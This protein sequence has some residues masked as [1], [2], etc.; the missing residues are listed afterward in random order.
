M[1]WVC[2]MVGF[3]DGKYEGGERS[4]EISRRMREQSE[5]RSREGLHLNSTIEIKSQPNSKFVIILNYI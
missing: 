2:G 4:R 1:M 5:V 3:E